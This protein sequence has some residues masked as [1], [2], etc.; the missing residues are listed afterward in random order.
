MPVPN[1]LPLLVCVFA[2]LTA[3]TSA[4]PAPLLTRLMTPLL[5]CDLQLLRHLDLLLLPFPLSQYGRSG[6]GGYDLATILF[7]LFSALT[8]LILLAVVVIVVV[9][10]LLCN[11]VFVVGL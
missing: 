9:V 2:D 6:F 7:F 10:L 1:L 8:R 5:G 4:F 11:I 3:L